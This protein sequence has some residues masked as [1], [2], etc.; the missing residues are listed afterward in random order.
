VNRLQTPAYMR[1]RAGIEV[2]IGRRLNPPAM[3]SSK[4]KALNG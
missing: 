2:G 3:P 4:R 1:P